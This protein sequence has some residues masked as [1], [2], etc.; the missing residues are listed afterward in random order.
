MNDTLNALAR[1]SG[2]AA[3]VGAL[4]PLLAAL[5]PGQVAWLCRI[6]LKDMKHNVSEKARRA[7]MRGGGRERERTFDAA[8]SL[9]RPPFLPISP[10]FS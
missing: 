4:R 7:E 2:R 8:A 6:I 5:R 1:A 3:K 9:A 10:H